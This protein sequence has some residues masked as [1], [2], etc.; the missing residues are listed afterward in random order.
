LRTPG[1]LAFR[2]GQELK[3]VYSF[4]NPPGPIPDEKLDPHLGLPVAAEVAQ[5]LAGTRFAQEVVELAA[6]IREH[7]FPIFGGAID[8]GPEIRWR[9]DYSREIET[10]LNYFR[11]IPYLDRGRAGDH[12]FIW[13]LN[14][15]QH[16]VLLAQAYWFTGD[17][18]NLTEIQAQLESWFAQN[19]YGHGI[20]WASAL[21]VAFRALSWIWTYHFVG[22]LL[23]SVFC[24]EW[25]QQLYRHGCHLE[26]NLSIY[27]SPN[28]HLLGEALALHALGR[29]F[30]GVPR[31][32]KWEQVGAEIMREEIQRQVHPD[33]SHFEQST[34]YHVYA[35]DMFLLHAVLARPDSAYIAKLQRMGDYLHA[36]LGPARTL[37]FLGDDDGGRLFHPYGRRD[38]FARATMAAASLICNRPGWLLDTA[39]LYSQAAWWRGPGILAWEGFY[40]GEG[41]GKSQFFPDAG[42]A[43]MACGKTQAIVKVGGF[44]PWPAGHSHADALS[45]VLRSGDE[46]ILI[47]PGTYTYVGDAQWR[48]WFR[49]SGAHN[50]VRVDGLDQAT[51]A[52]PFRW[53]DLPEVAVLEWKTNDSRDFL[54]AE[55]RFHGFTHRRRVEFRKPRTFLID[56]EVSGPAGEH[57]VEQFWHLGSPEARSRLVLEPGADLEDSWRSP[58]FGE[59]QTAPLVRV[60]RRSEL[61]VRLHAWIEIS[62]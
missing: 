54:E 43:V 26:N 48:D 23:P 31:A 16:L 2:F 17:A 15:H 49:G 12:K 3:N 7:A 27:F 52:G 25:L 32:A 8:S 57:H 34:Y 21:E 35:M 41:Q 58:V 19:P 6:K 39:D 4:A 56:D 1:E 62:P 33:G 37:P 40:P 11:R 36:V 10:G 20:N 14:R 24:K 59:K 22:E 53:T 42:I 46:E 45:I 38:R 28:T 5:A 50:T 44:G 18:T 13:E 30:S 47:D 60:N 61:P 9:R 29:S 51:I 55:C